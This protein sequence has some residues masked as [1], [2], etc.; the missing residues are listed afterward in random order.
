[1]IKFAYEVLS[2]NDLCIQTVAEE[3]ILA[4]L[5]TLGLLPQYQQQPVSEVQ[6]TILQYK[7]MYVLSQP[8]CRGLWGDE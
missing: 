1:M 6:S 5:P 7:M 3:K 8:D 2:L 4:V